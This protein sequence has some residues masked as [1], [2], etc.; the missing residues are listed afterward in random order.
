[1]ACSE[2]SV[3]TRRVRT[4]L[5]VVRGRMGMAQGSDSGFMVP[6]EPTGFAGRL[7]VDVRREG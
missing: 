3:V 4:V 1:M 2:G 7:D 5:R 6:D